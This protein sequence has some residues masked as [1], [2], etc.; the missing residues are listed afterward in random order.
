MARIHRFRMKRFRRLTWASAIERKQDVKRGTAIYLLLCLLL[1]V[2]ACGGGDSGGTLGYE[3]V[4]RAFMDAIFGGRFDEA[5]EMALEGDGYVQEVDEGV[6][7]FSEL[8]AK[9]EFREITIASVSPWAFSTG[10]V[11]NPEGDKR[12]QVNFQFREKGAERWS[13]GGLFIRV[14]T[15]GGPWGIGDLQLERPKE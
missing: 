8:Y 13:I 12:V 9:Y 10:G 15:A 7:A 3:G 11:A 6:D 14:L 5:K 1:S 2:N 4:N